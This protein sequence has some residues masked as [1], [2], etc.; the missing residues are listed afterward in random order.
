MVEEI[1]VEIEEHEHILSEVKIHILSSPDDSS[2]V[3]TIAGDSVA[4]TIRGLAAGFGVSCGI[5][6]ACGDDEQEKLFVNNMSLYGVNISRL[7][8]KKGS[9]AQVEM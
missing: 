5:I 3:K 7:R 6:G 1:Q 9:T 2:P 8:M 4:N